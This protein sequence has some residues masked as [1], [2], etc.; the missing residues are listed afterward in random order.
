MPRDSTLVNV[1]SVNLKGWATVVLREASSI[2]FISCNKPRLVDLLLAQRPSCAASRML[3]ACKS[4]PPGVQVAGELRRHS[5][6][7]KCSFV[8][9]IATT[10]WPIILI[11]NTALRRSSSS[12]R[13]FAKKNCPSLLPLP[14]KSNRNELRPM[15]YNLN[16]S[17]E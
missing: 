10:S 6:Q 15:P 7:L 11:C 2:K 13:N 12:L 5:P 8:P 16:P 17:S 3:Q 1:G 14:L 4:Y 9:I